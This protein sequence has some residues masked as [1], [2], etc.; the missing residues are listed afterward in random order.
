LTDRLIDMGALKLG[1]AVFNFINSARLYLTRRSHRLVHGIGLKNDDSQFFATAL[2]LPEPAG[3]CAPPIF[4][5]WRGT[6][7]FTV[8]V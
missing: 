8:S 3:N 1:I 5:D 2:D 7:L 4:I 6:Y